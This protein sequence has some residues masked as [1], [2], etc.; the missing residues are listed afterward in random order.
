MAMYTLEKESF[1]DKRRYFNTYD[2]QIINQWTQ[3]FWEMG[4][5]IFPY[6]LSKYLHYVEVSVRRIKQ[7]YAVQTHPHQDKIMSGS[8]FRRIYPLFRM[9]EDEANIRLSNDEKVMLF[10]ALCYSEFYLMENI[11]NSQNSFHLLTNNQ[12]DYNEFFEFLFFLEE[13]MM[14][15]LKNDPRFVTHCYDLFLKV[16]LRHEFPVF[17]LV[18]NRS[19]TPLLLEKFNLAYQKVNKIFHAFSKMKGLPTMYPDSLAT[20]TA[21]LVSKVTENPMLKQKLLLLFSETYD[22]Q[23]LNETTLNKY[24]GADS[25]I[26]SKPFHFW[27]NRDIEHYDIIITDTPLFVAEEKTILYNTIVD[28]P[29]IISIRK[30]IKNNQ[31]QLI[32][33]IWKCHL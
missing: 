29:T 8:L 30:M 26:E 6:T 5:I 19:S 23:M 7:G 25:I 18:G 14:I 4:L 22:I 12:R 27:N 24:F 10:G 31:K 2:D 20:L 9:V 1:G 11:A 28:D 21:L 17:N 15:P 16:Q 3:L 13:K 33:K 32:E